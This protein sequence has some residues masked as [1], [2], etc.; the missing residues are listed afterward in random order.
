MHLSLT[1]HSQ[2]LQW[3]A[4]STPSRVLS[5][6][7]LARLPHVIHPCFRAQWLC[8]WW[9][10][11]IRLIDCLG[12]ALERAS[13]GKSMQILGSLVSRRRHHHHVRVQTVVISFCHSSRPGTRYYAHDRQTGQRREVLPPISTLL[14]PQ[15]PLAPPVPRHLF[16]E[17]APFVLPQP[18][19]FI[20]PGPPTQSPQESRPSREGCYLSSSVPF[21]DTNIRVL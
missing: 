15:N 9:T 19:A 16:P 3:L 6:V 11:T 18:P 8:R 20:H 2:P 4:P 21:D 12:L 5:V 7:E 14:N 1:F 13:S 17:A 10:R